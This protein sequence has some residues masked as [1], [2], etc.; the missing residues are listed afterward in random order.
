MIAACDAAP[1]ESTT[2]AAHRWNSGV[3]DGFVHGQTSTSSASRLPNSAGSR[4]TPAPPGARPAPGGC[5][6]H[7]RVSAFSLWKDRGGVEQLYADEFLPL[8]GPPQYGLLES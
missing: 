4:L 2:T 6:G 7:E 3:H 1:P 8:G 5:H